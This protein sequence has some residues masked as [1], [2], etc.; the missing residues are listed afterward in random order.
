MSNLFSSPNMD[1]LSFLAPHIPSLPRSRGDRIPS[2][3]RT[4]GDGLLP[5]FLWTTCVEVISRV[6]HQK[7]GKEA[8]NQKSVFVVRGPLFVV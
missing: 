1:F 5:K 7:V 2:I 6:F 3:G 4:G 8:L